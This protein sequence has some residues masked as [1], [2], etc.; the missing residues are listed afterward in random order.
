MV[1]ILL[2][3]YRLF[4]AHDRQRPGIRFYGRTLADTVTRL[5]DRATVQWILAPLVG[6]PFSRI[7][8]VTAYQRF[9][10]DEFL[11]HPAL[12]P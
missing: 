4:R 1:K 6:A 7:L 9:D 5:V 3:Q 10:V 8:S 2:V 11:F 12:L